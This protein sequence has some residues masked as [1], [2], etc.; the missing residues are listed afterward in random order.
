MTSPLQLDGPRQAPQSG[1]EP[2]QL[3]VFLHG[4]GADGNDLIGLAPVLAPL[5][6]DAAFVSPDAPWPCD[7]AP[8]G[9]QW[10]SLQ[11]RAPQDLYAG[12]EGARELLDAFLEAELARSGLDDSRLA[13][14]GFSQGCM[15]ALHA[16]MRRPRPLA[17]VLG[18]SGHLVGPEKLASE[19][20]SR[21]PVLLV[22]GDADEVVPFGA[23]QVAE[24]ALQAAEV[25]VEAH[26][27][28]GL[29]H[30]IDQGGLELAARFLQRVFRQPGAS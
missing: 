2:E 13:L 20:R 15:M 14:F 16:A 18:F 30:G 7:M 29:G 8:M 24:Q 21:P 12:A 22:H 11:S 1:G 25:P 6:P 10:F 17:G 9:R 4:V 26:R 19:I 3:I 28:P 23:L 5:F 27:R